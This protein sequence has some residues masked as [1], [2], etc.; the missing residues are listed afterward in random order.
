[1]FCEQF[2]DDDTGVN[3]KV[4]EL[5]LQ[6]ELQLKSFVLAHNY[7]NSSPEIQQLEEQITTA[8]ILIFPKP[9]LGRMIMNRLFELI[10]FSCVT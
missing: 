4:D 8:T 7:R 1:V 9:I 2:F 10:V 3:D 6:F 5:F